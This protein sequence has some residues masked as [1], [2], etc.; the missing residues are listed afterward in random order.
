[1]ILQ[2]YLLIFA[3]DGVAKV[4]EP[5]EKVRETARPKITSP[6]VLFMILENFEFILL[7]WFQRGDRW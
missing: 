6:E 3:F 4:R 1:M 7:I 5:L 2:N